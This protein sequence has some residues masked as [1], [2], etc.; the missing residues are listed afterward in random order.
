[1][2]NIKRIFALII[3]LFV[4]SAFSRSTFP[5]Q[6]KHKRQTNVNAIFTPF[7]PLEATPSPVT[8]NYEVELS[9]I[10]VAPDGFTKQIFA[11]NGQY[12]GTIIHAN[13]GDRIQVTVRNN[14]G[15]PSGNYNFHIFCVFK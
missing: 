2:K 6:L 9:R 11:I 4:I 13:K 14:I 8:R 12:P 7:T 10:N 1:M 3:T 5:E 15:E